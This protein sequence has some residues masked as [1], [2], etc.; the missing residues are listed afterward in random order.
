M[1]EKCQA[2]CIFGCFVPDGRAGDPRGRLI[3]QKP[4]DMEL[5]PAEEEGFSYLMLFE[6]DVK[7]D[8]TLLPLDYADR[9]FARGGL[10]KLLL[11]KD[12]RI[13]FPGWLERNGD[14]ISVLV[15]IISLCIFMW[16]GS[17]GN[18]CGRL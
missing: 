13:A 17:Y 2:L 5:F 16:P 4:E 8:L 3:L 7:L 6:D 11:D 18:G 10:I 1:L 12:G 15:K 14:L 9:Y